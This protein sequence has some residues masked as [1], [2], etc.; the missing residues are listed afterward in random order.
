MKYARNDVP[1]LSSDNASFISSK[2]YRFVQYKT[3]FNSD[4]FDI[5]KDGKRK[6]CFRPRTIFFDSS[7]TWLCRISHVTGIYWLLERSS[8]RAVR[9]PRDDIHRYVSFDVTTITIN[10][11][12]N[13]FKIRAYLRVLRKIAFYR[14]L[15]VSEIAR[16]TKEKWEIY[17]VEKLKRNTSK[18]IFH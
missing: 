5:L 3:N 9:G 7:N 15:F 4:T 1:I 2:T 18:G 13:P 6:R 14:C 12:L 10:I 11:S 17:R 8:A 16:G